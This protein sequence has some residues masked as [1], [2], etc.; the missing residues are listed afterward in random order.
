MTRRAA[1][2]GMV[3]KHP[4]R[5]LWEGRYTGADGRRHSVYAKTQ[6]EAQDRLRDALTDAR[7]GVKPITTQLSVKKYLAEWL[8]GPVATTCRPRTASSYRETVDR[9]ILPAIGSKA[10]AK[11]QPA[12]VDRLL[13][14]LT[15]RGTL[16]PTTVR[17]VR[18]VL[19]IALGRALKVGLVRRNV[20]AIA[21]APAKVRRDLRPLTADQVRSFLATTG[22][23]RF[24]PL[25]GVAVST[26]LRLGEL[27]AIRWSD[28]DEAAGTLAVRHT[29]DRETGRLA[30]PK[31]SR[32]LRTLRLPRVATAALRTQRPRQAADR[33]AAGSRWRDND[34]VFATHDGGPL[35][36]RNVLHRLQA[37]LA[38]A[39]LPRVTFHT[40]G[41]HGYASLMLEAGEEL[42]V[43]SRNLGH[44]SL[45]TTA[46]IYLSILPAVQERAADRMD[47]LLTG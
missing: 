36:A 25:Y 16:S 21:A 31:T 35:D 22:G 1:T 23:D 26:G 46:D 6:R 14:D 32:S 45:G 19:R 15:A 34:Y 18:T 11:L 38:A 37:D 40:F 42:A 44:S 39:G 17:Y 29:L 43:I 8:A 33:L 12:D 9:Y 28:L 47:A 30:D 3:R 7:N 27:L 41:R 2:G 4:T 10:L 20:A 24:G 13:A 5:D